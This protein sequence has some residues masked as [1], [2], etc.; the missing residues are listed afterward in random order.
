VQVLSAFTI[1]GWLTVLGAIFH[2][3][4]RLGLPDLGFSLRAIA[5]AVG[6]VSLVLLL[7]LIAQVRWL[8]TEPAG[9]RLSRYPR[10]MR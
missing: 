2:A 3:P 6:A 5:L 7:F 9:P 10:R 4:A 1:L 8:P